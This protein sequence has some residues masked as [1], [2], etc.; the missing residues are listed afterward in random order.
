MC[1]LDNVARKTIKNLKYQPRLNTSS[2]RI[3]GTRKQPFFNRKHTLY[4]ILKN[5]IKKLHKTHCCLFVWVWCLYY[6]I[7]Y[8]LHWVIL[9]TT[10]TAFHWECLCW[11][12]RF[13]DISNSH[14][15]AHTMSYTEVRVRVLL[16]LFLLGIII[17]NVA[18]ISSLIARTTD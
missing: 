10:S 16:L 15:T 11:T 4:F 7:C 12:L 8:Y 5:D 1:D 13:G 3:F 18:G 6:T 2:M 17:K 9:T 14:K